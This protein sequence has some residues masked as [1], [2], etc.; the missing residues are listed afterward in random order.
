MTTSPTAVDPPLFAMAATEEQTPAIDMTP[1]L[2]SGQHVTLNSVVLT[3]SDTGQVVTLSNSPT[4]V[5]AASGML[6]LVEQTIDG[7]ND[8]IVAGQTYRL[9]VTYTA[10]PTTNR[11]VRDLTIIVSA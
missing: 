5:T 4:V 6:A 9:R 2:S 10:Y 11:F 8:A 7:N 1:D 3:N